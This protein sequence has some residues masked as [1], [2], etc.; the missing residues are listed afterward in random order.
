MGARRHA[1]RRDWPANLYQ[2]PTGYFYF[3]N[4]QSGKITGLGHDKPAAFQLA[5][6][7]NA[8]LVVAPKATLLDAML[9]VKRE[10]FTD[11]LDDYLV[12]WEAETSPKPGTITRARELVRRAKGAEFAAM[13][14]TEITTKDVAGFLDSLKAD[15]VALS[16]RTRLHDAFRMAETKGLIETGRNPVTATKPRDYQVKRERLTLEQFMAIH[17]KVSRWAAN[18]MMLALLTGQR[19]EDI[20][21]YKFS[22][23]KDGYLYITQGKTGYKLQ[24]DGTIRL[25]AVGMTIAD[26]I[27]QC[28]DRYISKFMVHHTRKSSTCQPGE[29]VTAHGLSAAFTR[30]RKD[31][32]IEAAQEGRTPPTF[33]EI[34]SLAE[35]LYK[36]QYGAE[37]AQAIMGHKHAKMTAEYDDLRGGGWNVVSVRGAV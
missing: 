20:T 30:A 19:L 17:G 22:D 5:R 9:G 7:A 13:A 8:K 23:Y 31:L 11:W 16:M 21:E 33:H 35:R 18:G 15:S 34:R 25:D 10:Y 3:R 29:Q 4:P 6:A 1:K 24:Q 27:K 37:F 12:L 14:I 32:K 36:K 26:C 2:Q 28:R